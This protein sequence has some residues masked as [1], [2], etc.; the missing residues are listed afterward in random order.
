LFNYLSR[1]SFIA[2]FARIENAA[3]RRARV[4]VRSRGAMLM[5][6]VL[7]AV[8]FSSPGRARLQLHEPEGRLRRS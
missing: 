8:V 1:L 4:A 3:A 2:L 6:I 5:A 7:P